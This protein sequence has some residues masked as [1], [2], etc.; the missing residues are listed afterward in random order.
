MSLYSLYT[1]EHHCEIDMV[2]VVFGR[3]A[4]RCFEKA[5]QLDPRDNEAGTALVDLLT[6]LGEEVRGTHS[7]GGEQGGREEGREERK[8]GG[9]EGGNE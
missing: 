8:K 1:Q 3:K 2:R 5:F 9:R 4:S 6:S 7:W